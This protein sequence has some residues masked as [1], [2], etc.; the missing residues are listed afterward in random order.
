MNLN[1]QGKNIIVSGGH[2]GIGRGIVGVLL[3][4]GAQ[5][6]SID[7]S[8]SDLPH[9]F[10]A[11]LSL[12]AECERV[13]AEIAAKYPSIQG[14]VNNAGVNDNFNLEQGSYA[15][16]MQS[17]HAN[18][19]HYYLLAHYALPQL[20]QSRGAIVNIVS[21]V[22]ETGQGGTSAYAAANGG[23]S[24]L[25]RE[26]AVE[27]LKYSIRV[28]AVVVAECYTPMYEAFVAKSANP[29]ALK[30]QICS[31]IPLQ[32]RMTTPQELGNAVAFLLS[33]RSSHTTGQLLHVDGGYVHLDRAIGTDMSL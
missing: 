5:P 19:T 6:I 27:L 10:V 24:A 18:L 30:A 13:M 11:D 17:I 4:E 12:P 29:E 16:F 28:N 32:Q 33:E 3:A 26:W 1:L 8:P 20:K 14:L 22:A 7:R 21:K 25:T 23:R 15:K 31:R 9:S 2:S